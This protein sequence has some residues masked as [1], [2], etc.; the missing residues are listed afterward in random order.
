M[1]GD[2]LASVPHAPVA[3][4]IAPKSDDVLAGAFSGTVARMLTAPLD[5]LKIRSQLHFQGTSPTVLSSLGNII[6]EEGVF[7]LWKGNLSATLLWITYGMSQFYLYGIF[8]SWGEA[9][10]KNIDSETPYPSN[11]SFKKT[12]TLFLAG[13]TAGMG[14]TAITYPFDIMRTQFAVQGKVK[15][16]TNMRSFVSTTLTRKGI[17]GFYAGVTTALVGIGP[18]MGFSF[19]IYES[20][21]VISDK[22][23][24]DLNIDRS[25]VLGGVYNMFKNGFCGAV[26][27]GTSKLLVYPLDTL[28]RRMQIQV[29][30]N[31]LQNAKYIPTYANSWDCLTSTLRNEGY[32]GLYKVTIYELIYMYLH[33]N[34]CNGS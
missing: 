14:A 32:R 8:K 28:K 4:D 33:I 23:L 30:S 16:Y 1:K 24:T 27:G 7:A 34:V 31:T 9:R 2:Q 18:Y 15:T 21:K 22:Y 5:V 13:A 10:S 12:L 19:A 26:A 20:L 17:P 6:K 11:S 29:L 3:A 25:T